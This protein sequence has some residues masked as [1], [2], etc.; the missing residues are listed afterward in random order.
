MVHLARPL[1]EYRTVS[2]PDTVCLFHFAIGSAAG[3]LIFQAPDRLVIVYHNITPSH[4][5]LG[6]VSHLV[7][8][9]HHGRRELAAFVPRAELALGVS[10]FN[11]RDLVRAGFPRTGVL[12]V[13]M[14][15]ESYKRRPSPVVRR[16]YE[17]GRT[18]VLFVGR[19]IPNKKIEDLIAAF[20]LYQRAVNP[21]SRLLLVGE[22]KGYENYFDRLRQRVAEL[23]LVEVVFAGHVDDDEL[24]AFYAAS[25]LFLCLSEHEGYCVPLVEAMVHGVP[26]LAYDAG[27]VAETLR[28]GGVLLKKKDPEMIAALIDRVLTDSALRGSILRTQER[29]LEALRSTDFRGLLLDRLGPVLEGQ[30]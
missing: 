12:P 30:P 13:I 10:E 1:W 6:F 2:S 14:N 19:I 20:A 28:G 17:D 29:A 5:F 3:P 4:F 8:L 26:V 15:L 22:Y 11:R 27:A 16:L 7:G 25:D 18:N 23:R 9:C 24:T 21:W